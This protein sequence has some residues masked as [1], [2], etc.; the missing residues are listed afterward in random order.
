M[1]KNET[2][3]TGTIPH[4]RP[5]ITIK[6]RNAV[7]AVMK[8]GMI[9]QGDKVKSFEINIANFIEAAG[10]IATGSGTAALSLS[11]KVLGIGAGDEVILPTYVCYSVA[12]AVIQ[13]GS[14]SRFLRYWGGLVDVSG[15]CRTINYC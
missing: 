4:S 12:D 9:A 3:Y 8:S 15:D 5:T 2:I 14:R 6:D 13:C 1:K 11:L 7:N 10:G